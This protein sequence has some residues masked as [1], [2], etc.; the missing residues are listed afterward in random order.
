VTA[1]TL[2][3]I[4]DTSKIEEIPVLPG[5][6]TA[7]IKLKKGFIRSSLNLPILPDCLVSQ[8]D[9][10]NQVKMKIEKFNKIERQIM[11]VVRHFGEL[12][13]AEHIRALVELC[14]LPP[15]INLPKLSPSRVIK[16]DRPPVGMTLMRDGCM[17]IACTNCIHVF[18]E[19]GHFVR[20]MD[21]DFTPVEIKMVEDDVFGMI[22]S[23]YRLIL[24][25]E[26]KKTSTVLITK[27]STFSTLSNGR[28]VYGRNIGNRYNVGFR[29]S[30]ISICDQKGTVVHNTLINGLCNINAIAISKS[31][32]GSEEINVKLTDNSIEVF[33]SQGKFLRIMTMRNSK[34]NDMIFTPDGFILATTL[35][36]DFI[37][38][39][40]KYGQS[41]Y[42]FKECGNKLLLRSNGRL[43]VSDYPN[44][45]VKLF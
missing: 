24:F 22:D 35:S 6:V 45:C 34:L 1:G 43:A 42:N 23:D 11:K 12:L 18:T 20:K 10:I 30:L 38:V 39:F 3:F 19:D 29:N 5:E 26:K 37:Q 16:F 32:D 9:H 8:N 31:W 40:T 44:K 33:S 14:E 25:D 17:A 28:I 13:T 2:P 36:R 4:P 41:V 7:W 27:C 15:P 21:L